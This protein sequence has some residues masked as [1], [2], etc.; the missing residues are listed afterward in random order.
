MAGDW[1]RRHED[2]EFSLSDIGGQ[3]TLAIKVEIDVEGPPAAAGL[4][5]AASDVGGVRKNLP[6]PLPPGADFFVV[7]RFGTADFILRS[8]LREN[9]SNGSVSRAD[10]E[11][12][13]RFGNSASP[14]DLENCRRPARQVTRRAPAAGPNPAR[15]PGPPA[16]PRR[17]MIVPLRHCD[18]NK[19]KI[20]DTTEQYAGVTEQYAG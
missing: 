15:P 4:G 19:D 8:L 18:D 12:T 20:R 17:G 16:H 9:G 6:R 3:G 5:M 2:S 13:S 10:L 11:H 14:A 7:S 1:R